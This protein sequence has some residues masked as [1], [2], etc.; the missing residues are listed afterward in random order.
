MIIN[1]LYMLASDSLMCGLTAFLTYRIWTLLTVLRSAQVFYKMGT[2]SWW[3][4]MEHLVAACF[5]FIGAVGVSV[6]KVLHT[7]QQ[8]NI[9]A[10]CS[11]LVCD[12]PYEMWLNGFVS[13]VLIAA[14]IL[15]N[16]MIKEETPGSEFEHH[17]KNLS[18]EDD[19]I[20]TKESTTGWYCVPQ[21]LLNKEK[22]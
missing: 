17:P 8:H 14:I 13:I 7:V 3:H 4:W 21:E 11:N 12:D 22:E 6:V 15:I 10:Q 5:G 18:S 19:D 16:H 9:S 2:V 1:D 20:N